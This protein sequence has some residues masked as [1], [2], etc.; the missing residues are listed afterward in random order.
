MIFLRAAS[1]VYPSV[2]FDIYQKNGNVIIHY[3]PVIYEVTTGFEPVVRELQSLAL[4]L[5]YV[6][7][8]LSL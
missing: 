2:T 1:V 8:L 5:G 6:T 3:I 4:P 7:I